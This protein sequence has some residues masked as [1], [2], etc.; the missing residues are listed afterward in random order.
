MSRKV[1]KTAITTL[2]LGSFAMITWAIP[3]IGGTGSVV[4]LLYLL[5]AFSGIAAFVTGII[6]LF[7]EY[8]ANDG[9]FKGFLI[10]LL[11]IFFAAVPYLLLP[12]IPRN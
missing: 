11:G 3:I 1:S 4:F 5:G 6:A 2:V 10:T 12:F 7:Q 8:K 9:E